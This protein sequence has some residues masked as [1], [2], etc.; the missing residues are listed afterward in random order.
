MDTHSAMRTFAKVVELGSFAAAAA[1]LDQARSAV[2]R[3]VA[4]LEQH[5]G[6]RLL[7]RTTRKLGLTDAGQAF[8]DR[9]RP[10][11]ADLDD[12]EQALQ[13]E[14]RRPSGR[15]RVAAPVSFGV[16][17]LGPTIADYIAAYPDVFIDLDLNDRVV[18]LVEE[19]YDV[20]V[21]IGTL[22]DST[23]VAR[24][25]APQALKVCASPAYLAA[26]GEPLHPEDLKR[27]RCLQYAYS[28]NGNEWRFEK[29]GQTHAVRVPTSLRANNGDILRTAAV[30]GHGIVLQPG[31]LVDADIDAGL[32]VPLLR[33]YTHAPITMYAVYPHRR[34]L[35]AKVRTFV[36]FLEARFTAPR[37]TPLE[38]A[39]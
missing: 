26:H 9:I 24:P 20:A 35:A 30:A 13:A 28:R 32:L 23:L 19:G 12:L 21:R 15:L 29:D 18:D 3:Q 10:I 14:D 34:Y 22:P 17:H 36:A 7:N 1:K 4:F 37:A 16:R 27:H 38:S 11:L 39:P 31:F 6:V 25:L 5:Y 33:D 8:Y 2:T